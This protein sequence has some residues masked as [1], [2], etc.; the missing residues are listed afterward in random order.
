MT[1]R[2]SWGDEA[3]L[4]FRT[5]VKKG[6][7]N[8]I[9]R[10]RIVELVHMALS[11]PEAE[12]SGLFIKYEALEGELNWTKIVGLSRKPDFPLMI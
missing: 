4:C 2:I 7:V 8:V 10:G 5:D 1:D 3:C 9:S 6:N 12:R 11:R